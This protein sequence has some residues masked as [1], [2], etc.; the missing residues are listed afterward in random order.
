MSE[1]QTFD[2][3]SPSGGDFLSQ[4]CMKWEA[5]ANQADTRVVVIRTGIV[6]ST[7]GGALAKMLPIFE[8]F[9]GTTCFL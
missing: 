6:M 3:S 8:M 9:L 5:E 2:E 1:N 7:E 4:V